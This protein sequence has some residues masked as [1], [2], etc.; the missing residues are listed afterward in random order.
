MDRTQAMRIAARQELNRRRAKPH[1]E[2][3]YRQLMVWAADPEN[4]GECLKAEKLADEMPAMTTSSLEYLDAYGVAG[5]TVC[6]IMPRR[7]VEAACYL[8]AL[9]EAAR[10]RQAVIDS[11]NRPT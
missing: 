2:K 7:G 6:Q 8:M 1:G 9:E 3:M 5:A 11:D 10:D 4:R